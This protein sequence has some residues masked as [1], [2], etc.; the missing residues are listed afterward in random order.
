MRAIV[1][2]YFDE[3]DPERVERKQFWQALKE[4]WIGQFE[5]SVS[6]QERINGFLVETV[7]RPLD[8]DPYDLLFVHS[9]D[10]NFTERYNYIDLAK[11]KGKAFVCYSG[12]A[13]A[14]EAPRLEQCQIDVIPL[15][16]LRGNIELFIQDVINRGDLSST[17]FYLLAG[18]DPRLEAALNLLYMFLPLDTELQLRDGE[19]YLQKCEARASELRE[20][21]GEI[22]NLIRIALGLEFDPNLAE[23]KDVVADGPSDVEGA[24][25]DLRTLMAHTEKVLDENVTAT[26][27][28]EIFGYCEEPNL[29]AN[30]SQPELAKSGFHRTYQNL[31]DKLLSAAGTN[32]AYAR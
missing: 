1:I 15:N 29:V 24:I 19:Q 6:R 26:L 8:V 30:N 25:A 23:T 11:Q 5:I 14:L 32:Q 22:A 3:A 10:M 27:L 20:Q 13:T 31:R 7:G 9:G 21:V 2:E 18:I 12:G 4:K 17:S 16:R 28:A